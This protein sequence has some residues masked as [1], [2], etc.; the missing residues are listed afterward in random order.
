MHGEPGGPRGGPCAF[1]TRVRTILFSKELQS[2]NE[3][4][5]DPGRAQAMTKISW[6]TG[7]TLWTPWGLFLIPLESLQGKPLLGNI[8]RYMY[9]YIYLYLC[10]CIHLY[11]CIIYVYMYTYIYRQDLDHLATGL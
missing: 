10:I 1:M 11:I 7:P 2:G 5:S 9:M 4:S 3:L 6:L 8:G